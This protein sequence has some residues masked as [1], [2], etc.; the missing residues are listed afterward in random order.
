MKQKTGYCIECGNTE[1]KPIIGDK[2]SYHY[3]LQKRKPIVKKPYKIK[4]VSKR[5]SKQNNEYTKARST[6]L[7]AHPFCEARIPGCTFQAVEIHHKRG[8]IE[9]L[10]TDPKWFLS[11]CRSCHDVIEAKGVFAKENGFSVSRLNKDI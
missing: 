5:R 1:P 6:Y 10:L 8:K 11:V 9:G 3:W 4:L 2:C 7:L